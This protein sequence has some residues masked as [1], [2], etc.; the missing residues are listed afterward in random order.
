MVKSFLLRVTDVRVD[1]ALKGKAVVG[2]CELLAVLFGLYC[3]LAADSVLDV[4]NGRVEGLWGEG[5]HGG[6]ETKM[7]KWMTR[8]SATEEATS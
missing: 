4:E 6:R 8:W 5:R 1:D 2:L 7:A 3:E